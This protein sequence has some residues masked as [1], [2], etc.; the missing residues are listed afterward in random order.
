MRFCVARDSLKPGDTVQL[1]SGGPVMTVRKID[2]EGNIECNWFEG[3]KFK[4]GFFRP[5]QLRPAKPHD[6]FP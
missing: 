6:V 5:E 1:K 3:A 4:D 2:S